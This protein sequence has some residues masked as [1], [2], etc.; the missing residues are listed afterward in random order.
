MYADIGEF[1]YALE[2]PKITLN[3]LKRV[4][5][6]CLAMKLRLCFLKR[7]GSYRLFLPTPQK[8]DVGSNYA[9]GNTYFITIL[10]CTCL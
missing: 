10:E 5:E 9:M 4:T 7:T 1:Q 3:N 6:S 8:G 2:T